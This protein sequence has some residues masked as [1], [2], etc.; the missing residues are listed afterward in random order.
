MLGEVL[1]LQQS[2]TTH[3]GF[4]NAGYSC[5]S[6]TSLDGHNNTA[7]GRTLREIRQRRKRQHHDTPILG[8]DHVRLSHDT[9]QYNA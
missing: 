6:G 9:I 1:A 4:P 7:V 8:S 3:I 5:I 2:K